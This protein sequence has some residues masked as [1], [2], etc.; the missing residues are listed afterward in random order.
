LSHIP[1]QLGQDLPESYNNW[2]LISQPILVPRLVLC[3]RAP[4]FFLFVL[5]PLFL[6][7]T[8]RAGDLSCKAAGAAAKNPDLFC[9]AL[10]QPTSFGPLVY[11]K[12]YL[13]LEIANLHKNY[14]HDVKPTWLKYMV[15]PGSKFVGQKIYHHS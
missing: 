7:N 15:Y 5:L 2:S 1:K 11:P 4:S 9:V 10:T 14:R 13:H 6:T 12:A 8:A 3:A